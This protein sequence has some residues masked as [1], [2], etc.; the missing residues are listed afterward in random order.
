MFYID[1][2]EGI[3]TS[4]MNEAMGSMR[5]VVEDIKV[6]GRLPGCA[7]QNVDLS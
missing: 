6:V 3:N 2:E 7:V 5:A 1:L 4:A